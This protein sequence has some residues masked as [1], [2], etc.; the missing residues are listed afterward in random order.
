MMPSSFKAWTTL[1]IPVPRNSYRVPGYAGG[2][3]K[4]KGMVR[5]LALRLA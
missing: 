3:I 5:M 2:M 1:Y 4:M